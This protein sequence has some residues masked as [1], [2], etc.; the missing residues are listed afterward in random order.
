MRRWILLRYVADALLNL[1]LRNFAAPQWG[2]HGGRQF[3][4]RIFLGIVKLRHPYHLVF[5][6]IVQTH[7]NARR[8]PSDHFAEKKRNIDIVLQDSLQ[9]IV[10]KI[11]SWLAHHENMP[12]ICISPDII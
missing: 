8:A 9:D 6:Q 4:I 12:Y 10:S 7:V 2:I 5:P 11:S 1:T 3:F